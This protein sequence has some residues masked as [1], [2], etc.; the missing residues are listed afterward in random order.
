MKYG[1]IGY[2]I[3]HSQSPAMFKACFP[4]LEYDLI[5]TPDFEEAMRIF[6]A[7]YDAI[8]VTAPFK[9]KA[10]AEAD[11]ADTITAQLKAANI[12]V[13]RDGKISA[14]NTDFWGVS[15]LLRLNMPPGE[16]PK[17]LVIGCGGA[18]KAAAAAASNLHLET[19]IANRTLKT[20]EEF[21]S[22]LGGMAAMPLD[23]VAE[24]LNEFGIIIYTL[25]VRIP[26]V[27]LINDMSII[28]IEANYRNPFLN[29]KGYVPG[30]E[31]LIAQAAPG[32]KI[33]TG[34]TPDY[35]RLQSIFH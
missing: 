2:P 9:E 29:G 4:D 8:N 16:L 7:E 1:L 25:P 10:F 17:T 33:M 30:K 12:L 5:E 14:M 23:D 6:M 21:C 32:F 15:Q 13:K 31:W 22:R 27:D 26:E 11:E 18:G 28:K 24:R 35:E 19:I 3:G 20:A 34:R